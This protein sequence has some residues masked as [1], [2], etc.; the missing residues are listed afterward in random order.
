MKRLGV[1]EIALKKDQGQYIVILADLDINKPIAFV[2]S[3][4]QVDIREVLES[5]GIQILKQIREVSIDMSGNSKGLVTDVLPN[6]DITV[7]R[8][9][10][11][12]VVNEELD[13]AR[14]E[15]KKA[16]ESLSDLSEK[17]QIK[18]ALYQ[19]KYGLLK[20]QDDLIQE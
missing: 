19:S 17:T 5:W 16:A 15:L 12:K 7:D 13:L 14:R 1:D 18:A 3:R 9:H 4:K 10:M 8:F 2:K 11:M 20:S 6:A